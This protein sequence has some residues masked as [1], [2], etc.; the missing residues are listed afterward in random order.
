M[1]ERKINSLTVWEFSNISEYK[2]VSH[3]ISGRRGGVSKGDLGELNLSFKVNDEKANVVENRKRLAEAMGVISEKI[4]FP[5]Q[6]H[7]TNI[8]VIES[9]TSDKDLEDTDAI[10]TA[11]KGLLISVMSADCVPILLYDF[12]ERV[13][14]AVH[15]GWRGSV[16]RILSKTISAM[17][18]NFGTKAENLI[19]GIGPSI[20]QEVYEVGEEVIVG[21]RKSLGE[22]PGILLNKGREDKAFLNLWEIN[23]R[24]LL[25]AG[26]RESSIETAGICTYKNDTTFFSARKSGNKAGRFAAGIML[27]T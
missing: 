20:C 7:S 10:L 21:V 17:E 3:Y 9:N 5:S 12:K 27:R 23:K 22:Q 8:K 19:A 4:L 25:E 1:L 24:Q 13:I 11:E 16:G 2:E 14:G 6:T 18:K 15:A 26:V